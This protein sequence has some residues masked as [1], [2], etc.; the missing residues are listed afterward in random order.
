LV[1]HADNAKQHV[2]KRAK[3]CLDENGL[4]NVPHPPHSPGLALSDFFSS[5]M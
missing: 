4:G 2:I 3:W 1:V 5:V